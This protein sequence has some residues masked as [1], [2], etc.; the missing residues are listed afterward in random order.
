MMR[1]DLMPFL[2]CRVKAVVDEGR[3]KHVYV[4]TLSVVRHSEVFLRGNFPYRKT[5]GGGIWINQNDI[6]KIEL[7]DEKEVNNGSA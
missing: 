6:E 1:R 2:G 4:C 7:L 3:G 5:V